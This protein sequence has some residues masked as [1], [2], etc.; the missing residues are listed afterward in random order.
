LQASGRVWMSH[1]TKGRSKAHHPAVGAPRSTSSH[2]SLSPLLLPSLSLHFPPL[3]PPPST[4]PVLSQRFLESPSLSSVFSNF[5]SS[6]NL[7]FFP[8]SAGLAVSF[9][10][11]DLKK[12]RLLS[13][14]YLEPRLSARAAAFE[15]AKPPP[16][17]GHRIPA[18]GIRRLLLR[19][20][21]QTPPG[22]TDAGAF[23][24]IPN[25][26]HSPLP[27][28]KPPKQ[29][30]AP[31]AGTLGEKETEE[32]R[33]GVEGGAFAPSAARG[34]SFGG[35]GRWGAR[36]PGPLAAGRHFHSGYPRCAGASPRPVF[37]A[38]AL[39]SSAIAVE[40]DEGRWLPRSA[41]P[42]ARNSSPSLSLP[43]SSVFVKF[44][45]CCV[46]P[47][48]HKRAKPPLE[49]LGSAHPSFF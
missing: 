5:G 16:S 30:M 20:W 40:G 45:E 36:L 48:L 29:V 4:S 12:T 19:C 13:G 32:E 26:S 37:L 43:A 38:R 44:E 17:R 1:I 15:R 10:D 21:M 3:S 23:P 41:S 14:L 47:C 46:L 2:L 34:A 49:E 9:Q 6:F 27:H 25:P 22:H 33:K 42:A 24:I 18:P 35:A 28:P 31:G 8:S 7:P 11:T 39:R